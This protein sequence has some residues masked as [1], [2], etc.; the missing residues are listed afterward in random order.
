M[1]FDDRAFDRRLILKSGKAER[2]FSQCREC[3]ESALWGKIA[4]F[5]ENDQPAC[6]GA[7][8]ALH[9]SILIS[10]PI[11]GVFDGIVPM[12]RSV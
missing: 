11:S 10:P 5:E 7:N 9:S 12:E 4:G 2:V 8:F 3:G 6:D 1:G